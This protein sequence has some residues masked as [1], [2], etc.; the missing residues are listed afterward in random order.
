MPSLNVR[1]KCPCHADF[2][3]RAELRAHFTPKAA[4]HDAKAY[5]TRA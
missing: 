3:Q 1:E 4:A 5:V 2:V